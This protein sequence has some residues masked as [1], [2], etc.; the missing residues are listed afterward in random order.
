LADGTQGE[1]GDATTTEDA[2]DAEP[3]SPPRPDVG[4]VLSP[5]KKPRRLTTALVQRDLRP[6]ERDAS[7]ATSSTSGSAPTRR[8]V[9]FRINAWAD[10][11]VDG[12]VVARNQQVFATDLSVGTHVVL[13]QNPRAK[14]HE[15][16]VDVAADGPDPVL[17]VRL[18]PRPAL[19]AVRAS[20]PDALVDVGGTGGVPAAETL[21]RPLLVALEQSRQEREVFVYKPGFIAYRRRHTFLAGETLRLD[22]VLEP[23]V[24]DVAPPPR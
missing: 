20:Q 4:Q 3:D 16:K 12:N 9:T 21:G 1:P 23:D 8:R 6:A 13:F 2:A 5:S 18:E 22:V 17:T 7:T 19:L 10:I 14:D 15:V 24:G 11:V